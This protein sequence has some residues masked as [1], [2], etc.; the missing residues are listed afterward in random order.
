MKISASVRG[1]LFPSFNRKF[2]ARLLLLGVSCYL[3]FSFIL[4]PLRIQGQS[5]EPTYRNG[6]FAFCLRPQYLFTNIQRFDVVAVR[7]S[8]KSVM[9]LKRVIGLPGD[10][11][12][13]RQGVL[14]INGQSIQEPYVQ[15]RKPWNLRPR[16]IT[17]DHV[18]VVGDNRS[19]TMSR[20][21]FGK[22]AI[23]RIMG[24]VIP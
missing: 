10:T 6:S 8:G 20:H 14:Y 2:L 21:I 18:Y 15:Q 12:E 16:T 9:L 4:I 22:V 19:T 24:G 3:F 5:M 7:F 11:L 1:F 17:P 13:F 23:K